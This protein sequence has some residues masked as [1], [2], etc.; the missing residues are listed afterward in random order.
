MLRDKAKVHGGKSCNMY[1]H[2]MR[3]S[4]SPRAHTMSQMA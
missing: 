1:K 2:G 3:R 4:T